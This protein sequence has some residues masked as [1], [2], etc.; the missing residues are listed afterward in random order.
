[1]AIH[2]EDLPIASPVIAQGVADR[3]NRV[4]TPPER[5]QFIDREETVFTSNAIRSTN[6]RPAANKEGL[7]EALVQLHHT[8]RQADEGKSG[9]SGG[10][11]VL[12]GGK[13][14]TPGDSSVLPD[15]KRETPGDSGELPP[16]KRETPGDSSELPGEKREA[17]GD[18]GE[19]P[20]GKR[21]T[22]GDSSVLPDGKRETPGGSGEL[23]GGKRKCFTRW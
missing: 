10:S 21:E 7:I 14:E 19:L 6:I 17:P 16:G 5:Q 18:S 3:L 12:P 22:P 23:P 9:T 1:M 15:G 8:R 4:L 2:L 13:R 20:P 11:S